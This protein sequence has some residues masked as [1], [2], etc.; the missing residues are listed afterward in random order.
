MHGNG[1]TIIVY[2]DTTEADPIW[3]KVDHIR[4]SGVCTNLTKHQLDLIFKADTTQRDK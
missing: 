4:V 3:N 2:M 1:H